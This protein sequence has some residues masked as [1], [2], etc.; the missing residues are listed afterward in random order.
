MQKY[1]VALFR[2]DLF[3]GLTAGIVALPLALAFGV[4]S[5]AG[6]AAGLYGA[7]ALGLVASLF[8]GTRV[9]I[10]GPTGP[11][12][13]VFA[14]AIAAFGGSFKLALAVVLVGGLLQIALGLARAGELV[15]YIPYPVISGFMSGIGVIIIL[16]QFA[17]LLG[18]PPTSTPLKA[19]ANLPATLAVFNHQALL[20][21]AVTLAIVFL[22]PLRISRFVPSPL[23][24]LIACTLFSVLMGF[25]VPTI[26]HIPTG[27]PELHLPHFT[28]EEWSLIF[29]LGLT[30]ALLGSIDSLLTSLVADSITQTRHLPNK[31]LIGQG[32]G[33]ILCSFIGG[34]PGAGATMRTVVNVNSGGRTRVSGAVHAIFLLLLLLGLAPLATQ[35]PLAVLAGILIKVGIDIL[36]YRLLKLL[37]GAPRPE[38]LIMG[39]VFALTVLVDLVVAVG[40]GVVLAM[41]LLTWRVKKE[42]H[43][44]F[45][46]N[47]GSAEDMPHMSHVRVV[48]VKGPLF[49]GSVSQVLDRIEKVDQVI[50]TREIVF[51]CREVHFVDL[52]AIF[53]LDEMVARLREKG[54]RAIVIAPPEVR[55]QIMQLNAPNL[56]ADIIFP[57]FEK[58]LETCEG[59]K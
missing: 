44:S 40:V 52:T 59:M 15:Y 19:L 39:T 17:P 46:E 28:L 43:I 47:N 11:M 10:S 57:N 24:A 6:A 48:N 26:G 2:G 45:H 49:F 1:S 36:D 27:L 35:V 30:L 42:A 20:L 12:T 8:G 22:T 25:S 18:S 51:N 7:I 41:G 5:G 13:V 33:N 4:A 50:G 32:L 9:Q 16:L 21:G 55:E 38:S 54:I 56:P 37:K 31:E 53:A 34:L 29:S 14:S 58:V 23:L 3:G